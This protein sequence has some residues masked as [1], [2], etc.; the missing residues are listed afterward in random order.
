MTILQD[1]FVQEQVENIKIELSEN[2]EVI[3]FQE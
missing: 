1:K 2:E 3:I